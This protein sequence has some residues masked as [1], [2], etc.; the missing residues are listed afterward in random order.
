MSDEDLARVKDLALTELGAIKDQ[1]VKARAEV[2]ARGVY[3]DPTWYANA[4]GARRRFGA[5]L[6]YIATEQGRRKEVRKRSNLAAEADQRQ[7]WL[8][9]FMRNARLLLAPEDYQRVVEA[10]RREV[11]SS[12]PISS[13]P[14][15][16]TP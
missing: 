2:Q 16:P 4:E 9:C 3:S 14:P 11:G 7:S 8:D 12:A 15:T 1:L 6:Q 5:L 10:T 13:P